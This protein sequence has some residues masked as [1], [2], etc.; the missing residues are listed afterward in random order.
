M[1]KRFTTFF[2]FPVLLLAF[3]ALQ[4]TAQDTPDE[5]GPTDAENFSL[6]RETPVTV[7]LEREMELADTEKKDKKKKKRKKKVFYGIKTKKGF[8]RKGYSDNIELEVFHYLKEPLPP[9]PFV[10]EI[11]WYDFKKKSIR[12]TTSYEPGQGVLLHGPYKKIRGDQIIEEGIFY[13]GT[14]H[15]R[16]T[17]YD[18]NDILVDKKKFYKGWPKESLV[19]YYDNDR[20]LLKEIIP[21]QYGKKEGTYFYFHKNGNVAIRGTFKENNKVGKWTEYYNFRRRRKK[22]VQYPSDPWDE[23]YIPYISKEWNRRGQLVY[24]R[25]Y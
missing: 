3:A 23:A 14:K 4:S 24:E 5:D 11:Y 18:K 17:K 10:P 9:D 15:G 16:W 25:S 13:I 1:M 2:I 22:E 12:I 21:M 19:R 6:I 20:K 8:T 7:D